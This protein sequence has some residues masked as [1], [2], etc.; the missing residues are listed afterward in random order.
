MFSTIKENF[1]KIITSRLFVLVIILFSLGSIL[2]HRVF[3]LQIV[4]GQTYLDNFQLKIQKERNIYSTRGNIYD[5]NGKLLAYN[6]LAYSVTIEDVYESGRNKNALLNETVYKT[7]RIIE[8]N[9]D[10]IIS[11]FNIILNEAGEYEFKVS[12]TA[13]L[14]F[15]ADVY[16]YS[17]IESLKYAEKTSSAEDVINYMAS[18]KYYSISEEYSKEEILKIITIRYDMSANS[19][20]K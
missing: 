8:D 18:S 20:Q 12:D 6:E 14:R 17:K 7:I 4:N 13:L 3:E 16:G 19:N 1:I 9:N 2:I 11:D 5:R 15:L 10:E